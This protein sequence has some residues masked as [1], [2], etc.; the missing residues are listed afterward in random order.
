MP[1]FQTQ[2]ADGDTVTVDTDDLG[3]LP[4]G[5]SL[6]T[7]QGAADGHVSEQHHK[8]QVT[9]A[10]KEA[11]SNAVEGMVAR[12]E[13]AQDEAVVEAVL[14]AHGDG[15]VDLESYKSQWQ[16][17]H[18]AP[19]QE[20]LQSLR[21]RSKIDQLTAAGA[22]VGV[23]DDH[24]SGGQKSYLAY[25]LS[26]R[27]EYD[28]EHGVVA[29]D[30]SGNRMPG[31]DGAAFAGPKDLLEQVKQSGKHPALFKAQQPQGGGGSYNGG[32]SGGAGSSE[33]VSSDDLASGDVDPEDV[34]DG[35]VDVQQ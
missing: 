30:A 12:D 32:G 25:L 10:K 6:N 31:G 2:T 23:K 14:E 27:L 13:A 33:V 5:F 29:T 24:L 19:L 15:D 28:P 22:E 1:E 9:R 8:A 11:A 21:S 20:Q 3:D 26:D 7:P 4:D 18:V 34:L 17:E 16:D 35:S